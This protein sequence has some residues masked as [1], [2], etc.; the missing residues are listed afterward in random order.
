M[1][2][3]LRL[4]ASA[5]AVVVCCEVGLAQHAV[6]T[7]RFP[8][9]PAQEGAALLR[10]T[11]H[12]SG[13]SLPGQPGEATVLRTIDVSVPVI[14]MASPFDMVAMA[15][16]AAPEGDGSDGERYLVWITAGG[17][18][19]GTVFVRDVAEA[20][21]PDEGG[22][23]PAARRHTIEGSRDLTG[24]QG[25]DCPMIGLTQ[26][27]R[28]GRSSLSLGGLGLVG[29]N[30]EEIATRD[31]AVTYGDGGGPARRTYPLAPGPSLTW[32]G[33]QG[34]WYGSFEVDRL[35]TDTYVGSHG[36]GQYEIPVRAN[37][38]WQLVTFRLPEE[39]P[40]RPHP[41]DESEIRA[42]PTDER[43]EMIRRSVAAGMGRGARPN[44]VMI[45]RAS[46]DGGFTTY[47]V[48]VR[49][50]RA[51]PNWDCINALIPENAGTEAGA[52]EMIIGSIQVVGSRVR[53]VARTVDVETGVVTSGS[54]ADG[55]VGTLG[56][57]IERAV[58]GIW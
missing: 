54:M 11:L 28:S 50:R 7:P 5:S 32:I 12:L 45:T 57:T 40:P 19:S 34:T 9:P 36:V 37:V 8:I 42:G 29:G 39:E 43:S 38:A 24:Q 6:P 20:T 18:P 46:S 14:G 17:C 58:S 2:A 21:Y 33:R 48:R 13:T 30:V 31:G 15:A 26:D 4:L 3:T 53:V 47:A 56:P 23:P 16:G 10:V 51:L 22:G 44:S 25:A 49:Y 35:L 27:L 1:R 52:S 55:T 41:C